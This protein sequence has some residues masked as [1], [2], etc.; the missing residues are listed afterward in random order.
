[1][2]LPPLTGI[3]KTFVLNWQRQSPAKLLF[4]LCM[5]AC[6]PWNTVVSPDLSGGIIALADLDEED[7]SFLRNRWASFIFLLTLFECI[8]YF[9]A[10]SF[11]YFGGLDRRSIQIIVTDFPL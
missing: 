10:T 1:L 9:Q 11:I 8:L 4:S 2:T 6:E 3:K 7:G 5:M